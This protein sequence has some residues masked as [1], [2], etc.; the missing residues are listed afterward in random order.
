[1]DDVDRAR[2]VARQREIWRRDAPNYDRR[3]GFWE[4]VL[5][6]DA[7]EWVCSQAEGEVLEVAVGTGR[8]LPFYPA[9][10]RLTGIDLSPEMLAIARERAH[11]QGVTV[12][13]LEGDAHSLDFADDS[14]D[15]VVCA[16]SL[17]NIPDRARALDEMRRVLRPS[18]LL[19]MVDHVA[20]T[21]RVAL[22]IQR[23]LE[24]LT[25]RF[26]GEHLTRRSL[27][28]VVDAGFTIE[29]HD[30]DKLGIVERLT[31]RS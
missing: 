21:S 20:S 23:L 7:R 13:L 19:V 31:A 6:G 26:G 24:K 17:C 4:R 2:E 12:V 11:Q 8:N 10:V 27:P 22:T 28:L 9:S 29:G 1:M 14:F 16:F 18:G 15:T 3:M 30:R 25:I 5:F